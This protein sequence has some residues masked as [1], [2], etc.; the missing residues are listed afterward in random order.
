M[1]ED[2]ESE[3]EE[4][5]EEDLAA[6]ISLFGEYAGIG[7]VAIDEVEG[8]IW[9]CVS[10]NKTFKVMPLIAWNLGWMPSSHVSFPFTE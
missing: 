7:V 9:G 6:R 8:E 5:T 3:S 2:N 1:S 4:V 10:C